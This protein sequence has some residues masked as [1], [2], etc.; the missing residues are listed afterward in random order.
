MK[1]CGRLKIQHQLRAVTIAEKN[2]WC[3]KTGD[4]SNYVSA[5]LNKTSAEQK[6]PSDASSYQRVVTKLIEAKLVRRM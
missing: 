1:T 4:M 2:V 5:A 3:Q 6:A